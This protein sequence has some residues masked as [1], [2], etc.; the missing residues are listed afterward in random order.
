MGNFDS[1]TMQHNI[2]LQWHHMKLN[3]YDFT[4]HLIKGL[5]R[6][7]TKQSSKYCTIG[8]VSMVTVEFPHEG[9]IVHRELVVGG[10]CQ[11]HGVTMSDV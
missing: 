4:R 10:V 11:W 9:L 6:L 5:A 3:T 1:E 7:T 2:S 8:P